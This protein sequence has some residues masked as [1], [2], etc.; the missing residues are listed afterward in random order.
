MTNYNNE[1]KIHT[2]N[3]LASALRVVGDKLNIL[4]MLDNDSSEDGCMDIQDQIAT[5][6]K[7]LNGIEGAVKRATSIVPDE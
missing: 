5:M 1:M 7:N 4:D 2:L 3:Q 6:Y